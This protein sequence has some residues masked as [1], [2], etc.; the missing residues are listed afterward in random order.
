MADSQ[1][2][3]IADQ[4]EKNEPVFV[5]GVVRVINQQGSVVSKD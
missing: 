1:Q 5:I 4:A 3:E 2:F